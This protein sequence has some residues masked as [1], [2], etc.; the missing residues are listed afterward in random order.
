MKTV[1]HIK[2][3]STTDVT[4]H[5]PYHCDIGDNIQIGESKQTIRSLIHTTSFGKTEANLK[6]EGNSVHNHQ[7]KYYQTKEKK[8]EDRRKRKEQNRKRKKEI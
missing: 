2:G 3:Y 7:G 6:C 5:Q 4:N 8:K 1:K